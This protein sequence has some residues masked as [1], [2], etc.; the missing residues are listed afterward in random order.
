MT[1]TQATL[2]S[3]A[4]D[5]LDEVTGRQWSD[6]YIR[7]LI[8]E[9][10][11]DIARKTETLE[12]RDTIAA[13]ISPLTAEYTLGTD[14]VRVGK[15]EFQ[16]TSGLVKR[17]T[18]V[19]FKYMDMWTDRSTR[20][21]DYPELYTVFGSGVTMKLIVYPA[22]STAG[23]FTIWFY[24]LP[25]ELATDG[26]A[27]ASTVEIPEGWNDIVLDYIEYRALRKDKD[28]RWVESKQLYD[29]NL[30]TMFDNTRRWADEAGMI[31]PEMS[32]LPS[33]LVNG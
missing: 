12:D 30:S 22:P 28:P 10:A 15:V 19:D 23:N 27:A 31:V 24:R 8:N 7:R 20:S 4:R 16:P 33:W 3:Y 6:V 18:Y 5:R 1:V 13:V 11:K 26:S 14:L 21:S 25:V 32:H 9:G 2:L 17:L 29:E